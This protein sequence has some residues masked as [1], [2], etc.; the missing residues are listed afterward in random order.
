MVVFVSYE[1]GTALVAQAPGPDTRQSIFVTPGPDVEDIESD[2]IELF[3]D[4]W[5]L[6][7][8]EIEAPENSDDSS[9][10]EVTEESA[11]GLATGAKAGI[12]VVCVVVGLGGLAGAVFWTRRRKSRTAV[13]AESAEKSSPPREEVSLGGPPREL[14]ANSK[15]AEIGFALPHEMTVP[16]PAAQAPEERV[17]HELPTEGK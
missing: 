2:P 9:S 14:P 11:Q 10:S 3:A 12:A 15:P 8:K 13:Q 16:L 5:A 6:S 7:W 17:Y 4:T 1:T